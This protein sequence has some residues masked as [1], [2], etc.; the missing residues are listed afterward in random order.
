MTGLLS[1]AWV[2]AVGAGGRRAGAEGRATGPRTAPRLIQSPSLGRGDVSSR[3]LGSR[4]PSL[5]PFVPGT[6]SFTRVRLGHRL[7][8]F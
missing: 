1:L 5:L 3:G 4:L 7:V 8:E 2:G 6:L